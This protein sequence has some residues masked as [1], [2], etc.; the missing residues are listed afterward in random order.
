MPMRP[1]SSTLI[2]RW[3]PRLSGPS[4]ASLRE[5]HIV[6]MKR[7][8]RRGA[9]SHLV[10]LAADPIALLIAIDEKDAEAALAEL[11]RRARQHHGEIGDRRVVDP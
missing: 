1:L 9:L 2:I 7:A 6:E 3:K 5:R 8:H 10:L 4:S 11:G